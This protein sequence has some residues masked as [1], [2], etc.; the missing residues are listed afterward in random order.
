M[1]RY[2]KLYLA[3]ALL[4]AVGSCKKKDYSMGN[5]TA[6]SEVTINTNIVGQSSTLPY[7]NGS[8]DVEITLTGKNVLSYKIDYDASNGINL[9]FLPNG[10]I[11]R[12]FSSS[13]PG[14]NSFR[15]TVV[16]YGAGG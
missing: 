12:K 13:T 14:V 3:F 15:I 2:T 16:A 7:G 9:E 6:P 5:L 8:G 1:K 11:T 4:L 10:K